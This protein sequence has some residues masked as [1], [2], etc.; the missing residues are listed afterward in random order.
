MRVAR[1]QPFVLAS[2]R[3]RNIKLV[4]ARVPSPRWA[5][6]DARNAQAAFT[7]KVDDTKATL[8]A[9]QDAG[10]TQR[11]TSRGQPTS[12]LAHWMA[13][14]SLPSAAQVDPA[15]PSFSP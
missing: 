1:G 7:K 3:A 2:P 13:F 14:P 8:R 15:S 6:E 10:D 4:H 9:Q 5:A 11:S 12:R